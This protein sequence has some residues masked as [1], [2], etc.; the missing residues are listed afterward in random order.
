MFSVLSMNMWYFFAWTVSSNSLKY[1][2]YSFSFH[3]S[4]TSGSADIRSAMD[5]MEVK[6]RQEK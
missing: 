3:R 5:T 4:F 1:I 6:W 2:W